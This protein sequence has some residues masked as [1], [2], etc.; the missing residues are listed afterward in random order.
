MDGYGSL[1]WF[2]GLTSPIVRA[3]EL[4]FEPHDV[5]GTPSCPHVMLSPN[6]TKLVN[7]ITGVGARTTTSKEHESVRWRASVAVQT[8][9]VEPTGNA[10]PLAGA[11]AT[12]TPGAPPSAVAVP[13]W[14]ATDC[15]FCDVAGGGGT[16]HVIFGPFGY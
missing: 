12:A 6:A 5:Y 1:T 4:L 3:S 11:H 2:I 10:A 15:R 13:N 9:A 14:T 16:G 7:E 8:T